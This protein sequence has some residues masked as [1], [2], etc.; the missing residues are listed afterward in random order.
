M[1]P[2]EHIAR[3]IVPARAIENQ[4]HV[5][6]ANRIGREHGLRYVGR[7]SIHDPGGNLLAAGADERPELLVATVA[8]SSVAAARSEYSYLDEVAKLG[9]R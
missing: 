5:A 4:V 8:R 1:E 2:Y 7:S 6:Y 9:L 3:C